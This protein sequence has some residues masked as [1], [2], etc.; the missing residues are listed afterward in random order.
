MIS[1]NT[2]LDLVLPVGTRD[3]IEGLLTAPIILVEYGDYQC[4]YCAQAV[5]IVRE[6]QYELDDRLC[7]AF[8]HFPLMDL[9]SHA[10]RA[11]LGDALS[12]IPASIRPQRDESVALFPQFGVERGQV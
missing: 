10:I 6:I 11:V 7:Y 4:P 2:T 5:K 3:H 8:R 12:V 9:H 1:T